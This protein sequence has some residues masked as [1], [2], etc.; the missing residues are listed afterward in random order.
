MQNETKR[1]VVSFV[2][3]TSSVISFRNVGISREQS[4]EQRLLREPVQVPIGI[5]TPLELGSTDFL[6]MN[7]SVQAQI[8]DNLRNL[9]STNHGER[10][11]L[12]GYGANLKPLT[13]E[14]SSKESFDEEAVVRINTAVL[15]WMPFIE[16]IDYSSQILNSGGGTTAVVRMTISYAVPRI[17]LSQGVLEIDLYVL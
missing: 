13:T 2:P 6:V 5:K 10:L 1:L 14:W 15:K 12:Y 8:K 11:V 3:S 7:Y 16:L 4:S 17:G 9:I